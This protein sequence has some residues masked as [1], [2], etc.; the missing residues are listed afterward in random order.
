M[1]PGDERGLP[2]HQRLGGVEDE[3][4]PEQL[5]P[6]GASCGRELEGWGAP[7]PKSEGKPIDVIL[8]GE[9]GKNDR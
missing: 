7:V 4:L 8:K 3:V 1:F 5:L 2:L 9:N 6:A